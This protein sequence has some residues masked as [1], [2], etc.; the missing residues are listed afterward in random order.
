MTERRHPK[1]VAG[2]ITP[3]N[4]PLSL[5]ATDAIPALLAGNAVVAKP[6][7]Q[8]A[9]T[10]LWAVDLLEEAGLPAGLWQ[11]VLGRGSAVGDPLVEH[12][13]YVAF[14]GSTRRGRMIAEQAA[15]RLIGYSTGARRKEPDARAR[16][17][18]APACGRGC[19]PGMLCQRRSAVHLGGAAV[20]PR[21]DL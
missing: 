12:A 18:R 7:T 20:R 14:T 10:V 17:R 11:V 2:L 13:D 8:T 1:G 15:R 21:E 4:Y 6:D 5:G 3:W 19:R 9:L 16:R